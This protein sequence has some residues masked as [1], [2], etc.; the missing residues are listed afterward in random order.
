MHFI[1]IRLC[2]YVEPK[3]I[4]SESKHSL[5]DKETS[6]KKVLKFTK[7]IPLEHK[8]YKQKTICKNFI[9]AVSSIHERT[10][11]SRALGTNKQVS[12]SSICK[13]NLLQKADTLLGSL[14]R[15]GKVNRTLRV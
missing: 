6:S 7:G 14:Y 8:K 13:Y 2:V 11:K 15:P 5:S 12:S 1:S 9:E 4:S 3:R 10:W